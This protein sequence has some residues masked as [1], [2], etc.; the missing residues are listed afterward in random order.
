M[1]A[2]TNNNKKSE[3]IWNDIKEKKINLFAM[4][5]PLKDLCT[6]SNV[7][8]ARCYLVSR[9]AAL[10]P[11]LEDALKDKYKCTASDRF[12]IVETK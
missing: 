10:L 12:I 8:P 4:E 2:D 7:D 5:Q 1:S 9:A 6:F 11:A 3:Q